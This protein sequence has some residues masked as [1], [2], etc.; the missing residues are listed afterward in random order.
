VLM[1]C[2]MPVMDGFEASR[3]IRI[4]QTGARNPAIPIVAVT[5]AAMAGDRE[6]C[7]R[8]GM[9]DYLAK[10]VEPARMAQMLAKWLHAM[11]GPQSEGAVNGSASPGADPVFDEQTLLRR[12]MG[13]RSTATKIVGAFLGEAP[14]QI[15]ALRRELESGNADD[16]RR[17]AHTLKGAAANISA[18][19][20]RAVALEAERAAR[21]GRLACAVDLLP[22]MEAEL[23][24]L[25]NALARDGWLRDMTPASLTGS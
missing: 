22:S 7:L 14:G 20:L 19:A 25:R 13:S 4:A 21:E 18:G 15:E 1:D 10:P 11:P 23:H 9:S 3:L 8:A 17:L 6:K 5:A 16:A 2:E 12:V 24:K